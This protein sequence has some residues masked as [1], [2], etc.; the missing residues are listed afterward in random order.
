[1]R[2]GRRAAPGRS[3]RGERL[4]HAL[5]HAR[6]PIRVAHG[7]D[8]VAGVQ[9]D[10]VVLAAVRVEFAVPRLEA[11]E[12]VA[13]GRHLPL[14]QRLFVD[15]AAERRH[16]LRQARERN[17]RHMDLPAQRQAGGLHLVAPDRQLRPGRLVQRQMVFDAAKLRLPAGGRDEA[18]PVGEQHLDRGERLPGRIHEIV[19]VREQRA[20]HAAAPVLLEDATEHVHVG[21]VVLAVRRAGAAHGKDQIAHDLAGT[22]RDEAMVLRERELPLRFVFE[23]GVH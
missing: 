11:R 16:E 23:I 21:C 10:Q 6:I 5:R 13:D 1:M 12:L 19:Q 2:P 4:V 3:H 8:F 18:V 14:A 9:Q 7:R 15:E 20:A 17:A 22:R